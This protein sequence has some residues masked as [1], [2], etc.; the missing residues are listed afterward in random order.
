MK[1]RV[2]EDVYDI[3]DVVEGASLGSLQVLKKTSGESVKTI[4]AAFVWVG[5]QKDLTSES[6]F[7]NADFIGAIIALIF[8]ARRSS[9]DMV[10][11]DEASALTP[12]E[13]E[14]IPD[15]DEESAPKGEAVDPPEPESES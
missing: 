13:F 3:Q 14:F 7:D 15:E 6:L 1:I 9:G 8:L 11:W 12:H 4:S 10:T 2:R 5:E